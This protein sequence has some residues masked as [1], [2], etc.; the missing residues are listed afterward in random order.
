VSNP[1]T[2]P[3]P[4]N[5]TTPAER[6]RADVNRLY[7]LLSQAPAPTSDR[8]WLDAVS[9]AILWV[10]RPAAKEAAR[11][12]V[13]VADEM[14]ARGVH[15]LDGLAAARARAAELSREN[16]MPEADAAAARVDEILS[17]LF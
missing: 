6:W 9:Y 11:V 13:A 5:G 16:A 14:I 7:D 15:S 17:P 10:G 2:P 8:E 4:V 3:P 1:T 12:L